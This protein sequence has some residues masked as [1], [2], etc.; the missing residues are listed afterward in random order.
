[1][2]IE[3][4]WILHDWDDE[5]CIKILK[6]C[7]ESIPKSGGK[8]IIIEAIIEAEKGEK[9]N[10]KLSDVGLMFDLVMMAHTNRGKER[11]AQEW[12][13]L[14][15]QAGFTTHTITPIQAIQSLIQCFP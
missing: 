4:Q 13:F 6:K 5:E 10:K 3:L 12:A 8:V 9:K 11:T 15:H 14:I 1:M 7:K 2:E